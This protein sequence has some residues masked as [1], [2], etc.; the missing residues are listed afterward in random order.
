MLFR[1]I[2][3]KHALKAGFVIG[4]SYDVVLLFCGLQND[5]LL[6]ASIP[7]TGNL[8]DANREGIFST[9]GY[10]SIYFLSVYCGQLIFQSKIPIL[11]FK[12]W[13]RYAL[14]SGSQIAVLWLLT[15]TA[16]N[17]WNQSS[18]RIGNFS[19]VLWCVATN[20]T[21]LWF[22]LVFYL[23]QHFLQ[24]TG[25][26]FGPLL[27]HQLELNMKESKARKIKDEIK[28]DRILEEARWRLERDE[29]LNAPTDLE[30]SRL[31][32]QLKLMEEKLKERNLAREGD[33]AAEEDFSQKELEELTEEMEKDLQRLRKKCLD[34][35][36]LLEVVKKS[37]RTE[38]N[39]AY[40]PNLTLT[41]V[42][43]S[44]IVYNGLAVFLL[45][46][47]LTGAINSV[48]ISM[49]TP[50]GI[51]LLILWAYATFITGLSIVL[52]FHE[53]QLKFW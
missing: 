49:Y 50:N 13:M 40:M 4:L 35:S 23:V 27:F 8:L 41:P 26:A 45:G 42:T 44:A 10:T 32:G 21:V 53:I 24:N 18:R 3:P 2:H 1:L 16:H 33:G 38:S 11:R 36:S 28:M 30:L 6:N 37:G 14:V 9:I 5:Y 20:Y 17:L 43:L 22:H 15:Y 51:S 39:L 48:I 46:N 52:Y 25:L 19:Y 7:R 34:E 47:L 31:E 12:D 29:Q